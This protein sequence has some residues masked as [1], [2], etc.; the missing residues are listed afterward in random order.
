MFAGKDGAYLSE[1]LEYIDVYIKLNYFI[2]GMIFEQE[3]N[4]LISC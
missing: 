4:F 1:A 2:N 3:R